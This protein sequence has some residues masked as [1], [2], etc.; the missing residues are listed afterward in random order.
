[1]AA[2]RDETLA[3]PSRGLNVCFVFREGRESPGLL[4]SLDGGGI[5]ALP[6]L[7]GTDLSRSP[8]GEARSQTH[9]D[10]AG[11]SVHD[12]GCAWPRGR[13]NPLKGGSAPCAKMATDG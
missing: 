10:C 4:D 2:L 13:A 3:G 6:N 5:F 1:M 12:P 9:S 8:N 7:E 11:C